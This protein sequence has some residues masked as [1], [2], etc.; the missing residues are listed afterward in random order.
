MNFHNLCELFCPLKVSVSFVYNTKWIPIL[1]AQKV[2]SK[3]GEQRTC[4]L[5]TLCTGP[6]SYFN[7]IKLIY[8]KVNQTIITMY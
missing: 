6:S 5:C 1:R 7:P 4:I 8:F 3:R 2:S